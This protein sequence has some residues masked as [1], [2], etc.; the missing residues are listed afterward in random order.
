MNMQIIAQNPTDTRKK[1]EVIRF[2]PKAMSDKFNQGYVQS[3]QLYRREVYPF[4]SDAARA[5]YHELENHING[6]QKE[7]AHVSYSQ[8]Q[9]S[10]LEGAR[11]L[12]RATIAKGLNEL[13]EKGVITLLTKCSR[14]GNQYR[15]NEVSLVKNMENS[16]K[17]TDS[18]VQLVNR[19]S[20]AS[21]PLA[22]QLVNTTKKDKE[23]I[24][25]KNKRTWLVFENLKSEI[26]SVNNSIDFN[27][28]KNASWFERELKA[29]ENFNAAK[30]HNTDVMIYLFANW[31]IKAYC[32]AQSVNNQMQYKNKKQP[33]EKQGSSEKPKQPNT[34]TADQEQQAPEKRKTT[35][36]RL[37][38]KQ[39]GFFANKLAN[40]DPFAEQEAQ[41][42]E[43]RKDLAKRL[44]IK[45]G[46]PDYVQEI[47]PWLKSVGYEQ[48]G[49]N[50]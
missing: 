35:S 26:E 40:Y 47:M 33:S 36:P 49:A 3:S 46:N 30:N 24:K 25:E 18:V 4:L 14:R 42:G 15:I 39:L 5:V 29:F 9:G 45:L 22:V 23:N 20:S 11:K 13:I 12:G 38:L 28:I 8:L 44:Q 43:E 21:E 50:A 37:S 16:D 27:E 19:T 10:H 48:K 32:K 1:G 41:V 7:T 31:L 2:K 6:F 34:A 17:N